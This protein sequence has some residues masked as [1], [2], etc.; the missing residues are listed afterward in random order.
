MA[1]FD[2][3]KSEG[4]RV[5]SACELFGMASIAQL[6]LLTRTSFTSL[7]DQFARA[8]TDSDPVGGFELQTAPGALE[9]EIFSRPSDE[10]LAVV[11]AI[12]AND[13]Q[14]EVCVHVIHNWPYPVILTLPLTEVREA[15]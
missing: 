15:A 9:P 5:N 6:E 7:R 11:S 3:L 14:G 13:G 2:E 10:I 8:V 1:S 12:A 4:Y